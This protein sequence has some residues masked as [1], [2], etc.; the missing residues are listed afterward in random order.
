MSTNVTN[1]K[2]SQSLPGTA[3]LVTLDSTDSAQLANFSKGMLCTNNSSGNTG[4][5]YRVDYEGNSFLVNPIQPNT[6]FQSS[7]TYGYLAVS[8]TV[9]VST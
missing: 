9:I 3:V 1:R 6:T 8:E 5:I 7:G 2:A 4:T